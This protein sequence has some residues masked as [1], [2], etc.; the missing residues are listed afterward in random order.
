MTAGYDSRLGPEQQFGGMMELHVLRRL[1][2]LGYD[3]ELNEDFNAAYDIRLYAANGDIVPV[4]V[5]ARR[6]VVQR[7][8]RRRPRDVW[9]FDLT[10][11]LTDGQDHL[12]VLVQVHGTG[13]VA[14]YVAPSAYLTGAGRRS[15][16]I[17]SPAERFRGYLKPFLEDWRRQVEAVIA[18]RQKHRSV[19]AGQLNLFDR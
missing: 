18:W 13:E 2:A 6:P 10:G 8:K 5:K 17:T 16:C 15:V 3:V 14:C 7:R 19:A 9:P 12:F 4:E 1:E 11:G